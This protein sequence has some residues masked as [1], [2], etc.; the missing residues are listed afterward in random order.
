[1]ART[2]ARPNH[3]LRTLICMLVATL[4][5]GG[6]LVGAHLG[7]T[8]SLAPKLGLDLEGGTQLVLTPRVV[9][10]QKVTAAQ[11][12]QARD[13]ISERVDSQGVTGAEVTTQGENN[14]VVSMAGDP[15]REQEE[16]LRQSSALQFRPVLVAQ[17]SAVTPTPTDTATTPSGSSTSG[18]ETSGTG[19][20]SESATSG[21]GTTTKAESAS[22]DSASRASDSSTSASRSRARSALPAAS[23]TSG[24]TSSDTA[25][26]TG[27]SSSTDSASES[28]SSG[29]ATPSGTPTSPTDQA[30]VTEALTA[31][32]TK[33]D[34]ANAEALANV[35]DDPAKPLVTCSSD[36]AEKFILGPVAVYGKDITDAVADYKPGPNGQ[37]TPEVEIRLTF[38]SAASK[39]YADLSI[40]MLALPSPRNRLASTLDSRVIVAPQFNE[41]ITGG[42]SSITGGFT[43]DSAQELA[44]QLK[45]GALPI[46]FDLQTRTQISPTLGQE[47]LRLGLLAGL[48]GLVLVVLYS[49]MQYRALGLVTVAS[50]VLAALITYLVITLLGWAQNYRLDMAGVTGLIVAIGVTADSFI[51][52]FERVRDE[53]REGR[54]LR[55]AVDTGW[56]RAKRTILAA[57]GVNFLG[58][59]VLYL[60]ASSSVRGFA[61]TLGL[62][63]LIDILIVFFF[64]HPI[65]SLLARRP[66]FADGHRWSGLDPER[67]GVSATRYVGRGRFAGPRQAATEGSQ[68]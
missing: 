35:V 32:F 30:W 45:F 64:T 4:A 43:Y 52:Y 62:T 10:D 27:T 65:V 50:I 26:G 51:V 24:S 23:S 42:R 9:G 60:L 54:T 28:A 3:A 68:A 41:A 37:P 19:T 48:V 7:G 17:P 55:T 15:S 47:Q 63:T 2:Q 13:I 8:A 31:E 22:S 61:F 56:N 5:L 34:C 59:L 21:S 53:V 46:S 11:V 33:L 57:D 25:S 14:I 44:K 20:S 49:L 38:D 16:N 1:M 6:L 40:E 12:A 36:G 18:S 39:T 67:L 29:A 58:A 66:F